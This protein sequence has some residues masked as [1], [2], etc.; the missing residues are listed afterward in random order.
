MKDES[1]SVGIQEFF[2]MKPKMHSVLVGDNSEHK[3]E[4]LVGLFFQ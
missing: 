3:K 4:G 1:R 2:G